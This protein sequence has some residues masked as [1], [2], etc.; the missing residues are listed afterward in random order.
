MNARQTI[1]DLWDRATPVGPLLDAYRDEVLAGVDEAPL[2]PASLDPRAAQLLEAIRTHKG[3]WTTKTVQQLYRTLNV[4]APLR[5]TARKDLA[6]LHA[7]GHLTLHDADP[8]RHYY[9]LRTRQE[10]TA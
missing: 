9:T 8:G 5:T 4:P 3:E 1:E 2:V 7:M 10:R 6:A